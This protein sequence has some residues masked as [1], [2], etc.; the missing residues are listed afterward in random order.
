[1]FTWSF[2]C[3]EFGFGQSSPKVEK[4]GT[5]KCHFE[6]DLAT[7]FESLLPIGC[8]YCL[9]LR[10][11]LQK[12]S[13]CAARLWVS[14]CWHILGLGGSMC[15]KYTTVSK[16]CKETILKKK[17]KKE[18]LLHFFLSRPCLDKFEVCSYVSVWRMYRTSFEAFFC[19]GLCSTTALLLF[20]NSL[21]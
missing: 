17:K 5:V 8:V 4:Y 12:Q 20:S 14:I 9:S 3:V 15:I 16:L 7:F 10:E 19:C 18:A 1:M 11:K 2:L 21:R 13:T 6:E